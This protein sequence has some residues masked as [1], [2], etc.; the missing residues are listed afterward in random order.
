MN[1]TAVCIWPPTVTILV[2]YTLYLYTLCI[3]ISIYYIIHILF[4][5]IYI[6]YILFFIFT[7]SFWSSGPLKRFILWLQAL[8]PLKF[9]HF[10]RLICQCLIRRLV[11]RR[12]SL[13][14]A[15]RHTG[16][17]MGHLE[18]PMEARRKAL[19]RSGD[20]SVHGDDWAAICSSS[21]ACDWSSWV[22]NT[23]DSW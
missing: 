9:Q 16:F 20:L 14:E 8:V 23:A 2:F 4:F 18:F 10:M 21:S 3:I 11:L 15:Q 17:L 19:Q 7:H 13:S 5:Y 22:S 12:D 1:L 6:L